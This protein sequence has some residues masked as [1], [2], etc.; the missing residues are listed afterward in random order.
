MASAGP[1]A[2]L[3]SLQTDNHA[4]TPPLSFLQ[5]GCPSC[6]PTNSVKALKA[7][8]H[9]REYRSCCSLVSCPTTEASFCSV[10]EMD[11]HMYTVYCCSH[12]L[13]KF[14]YCSFL[15]W[16]LWHCWL[17]IRK[18]IQP[19][20]IEWWGVGVVICLQQGADCL[21]M[22]QLMPLLSQNAS[23]FPHFNPDWFY[24]SSTGL[25]RL[26]WKRGR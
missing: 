24:L 3:H 13:V 10:V 8:K 6:R 15:P 23:L 22:V 11:S 19:V 14:L 18:S 2:S 7:Q 4:S 12:H 21:H 9:Q 26:S 25:S 5:A 17:G 16:V 1:Y 20:E